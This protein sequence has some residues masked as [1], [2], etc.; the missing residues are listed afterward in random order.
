MDIAAQAGCP[1]SVKKIASN[2]SPE[3]LDFYFSLGLG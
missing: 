1:I 2:F 3:K